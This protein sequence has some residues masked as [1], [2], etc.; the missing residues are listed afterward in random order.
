MIGEQM[1][2]RREPAN[3][4]PSETLST[5]PAP[6]DWR[7]IA[8]V[9]CCGVIAALSLGKLATVG[10]QMTADLGLSLSQLG[11]AISAVVGVSAAAGLPASLFIRRLGA[12]RA[13]VA[14]LLMVSVA[15][16]LTAAATGLVTLISIR[17]FEGVGYLLVTIAGPTLI[18]HLAGERDRPTALAIWGTFVPV[19]IGVSTMA[20]GLLG[21]QLGWRGWLGVAAVLPLALTVLTWLWLRPNASRTPSGAFPRPGALAGPALLST[22]FCVIA[23]LTLSAMVLLPTFLADG[24]GQDAAGAGALTSVISLISV[25]G[26]LLAAMLL[27][28][29]LSPVLLA[30][31]GALMIPAAWL[32]FV[33]DGSVAGSAIGAGVVSLENGILAA[34]VFAGL[35]LVVRSLDDLDVG[36]GLVA[37]LGSL[38]SLV[39]P[40]LFGLV[41]ERL[42]W[43]ALVWVFCAGV[44][45]GVGLL[46]YVLSRRRSG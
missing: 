38:G 36:N 21:P 33:D 3:D 17:V 15:A 32:T 18:A 45:S 46:G 1:T 20:G 4:Q 8:L 9:Y 40:P 22:A 14:G 35:P 13:F 43:S 2:R 10:P 5:E 34:V 7:R 12:D 23:L 6:T 24:R 16:A 37:Q 30:M 28:R 11:W 42:G 39:G 31:S 29:G 27:R 26:G 41:A 44:A 25:P 19:G